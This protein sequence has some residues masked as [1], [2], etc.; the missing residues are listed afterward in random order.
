VLLLANYSYAENSG[1]GFHL[2]AGPA[3]WLKQGERNETETF[4]LYGGHIWYSFNLIRLSGGISGRYWASEEGSFAERSLHQLKFGLDIELGGFTPGITLQFPLDED[5]R[6]FI[7]FVLGF[8]V[9]V[10]W[11]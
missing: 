3:L 2:R 1:Y 6:D 10:G 11:E 7:N 9:G 4:I 5:Y 8:H